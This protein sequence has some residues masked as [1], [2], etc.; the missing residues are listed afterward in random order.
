MPESFHQ[1]QLDVPIERVW[2]FV[3]NPSNWAPLI[4]GY[5]T[6]EWINDRQSFWKFKGELGK[7]K[8]TV[9]VRLDITEWLEP[10]KISFM[11][12]GMNE[13]FKGH[14]YFSAQSVLP[15]QTKITGYLT[16]TSKGM[17]RPVINPLLKT[18]LPKTT[19]HLTEAIA[20]KMTALQTAIT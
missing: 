16:I 6:H 12:T 5:S 1:L 4:K 11:L 13:N 10:K 3:C 2:N 8:K 17:M 9:H 14:G 19:K 18:V 7:F 20:Q 15:S